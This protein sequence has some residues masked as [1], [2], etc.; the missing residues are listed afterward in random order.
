[1]GLVKFGGG[2]AQISGRVGGI[3]YAKSRFGHVARNF[4]TP[5]NPNSD[6][7]GTARARLA[8]LASA[9][10]E[11]LTQA[12]RDGWDQFASNVPVLNRLGE[13]VYL[14]GF[15]HYIRSNT[16][17]RACGGVD[18]DASPSIYTLPEKDDAFAIAISEATQLISV[19]FDDERDYIDENGAYLSIQM[20][21]PKQN[22][23]KFF[24]GPWRFADSIDG[25][26]VAPPTSPTTIA[27]PF[28]VLEG[29]KVWAQARIIRADGRVSNLFRTSCSVGA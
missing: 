21:S 2:V 28:P 13:T 4:S 25:D 27:V 16:A 26:S 8:D 10:N 11:V 24:G 9:W 17:I 3:V 6:R 14:T 5:V 29:Q 20:G 12:Q 22:S 15:N 7:Q 1:M 19:T 18:V 23:V